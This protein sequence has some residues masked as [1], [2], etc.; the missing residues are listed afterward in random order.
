MVRTTSGYFC[1]STY[2]G[3]KYNPACIVRLCAR[4]DKS[5]FFHPSEFDFAELGI[6]IEK[7]G[8]PARLGIWSVI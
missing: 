7:R 2:P 1:P 3:G 8:L 6:W 5:D 4:T